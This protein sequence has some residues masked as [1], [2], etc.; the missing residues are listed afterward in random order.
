M[1]QSISRK[2]RGSVKQIPRVFATLDEVR[3]LQERSQIETSDLQSG[4]TLKVKATVTLGAGVAIVALPDGG[5]RLVIA[6]DYV[7]SVNED[8]KKTLLLSYSNKYQSTFVIDELL[9]IDLKK[10]DEIP[11]DALQTYVTQ[12][13]WMA[14]SR[15][16]NALVQYGFAGLALPKSGKLT[17]NP[18]PSMQ[19]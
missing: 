19:K 11:I 16:Q 4:S 13:E 7:V 3:M 2:G 17:P 9:G 14:R 5:Q 15:A 12:I 8:E 1:A 18:Q 10:G 6:I